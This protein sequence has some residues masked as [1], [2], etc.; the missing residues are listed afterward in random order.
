[1]Q[2]RRRS[3]LE[4]LAQ[5]FAHDRGS[6]LAAALG[7]LVELP[8]HR[9]RHAAIQG[10]VFHWRNVLRCRAEVKRGKISLDTVRHL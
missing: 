4:I 6:G 1:M 10:F 5:G 8:F 7:F 3:P 2:G 9:G